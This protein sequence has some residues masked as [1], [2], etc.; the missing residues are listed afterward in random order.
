MIVVV[1]LVVVVVVVGFS[2]G[3]WWWLSFDWLDLDCSILG[4]GLNDGA[5]VVEKERQ[6]GE[7]VCSFIFILWIKFSYK[8]SYSLKLQ[9]YSIK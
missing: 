1:A 8:I 4:L 2:F 7:K 6:R 9:S 3:W 5:Q